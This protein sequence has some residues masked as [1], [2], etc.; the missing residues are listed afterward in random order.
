M[1]LYLLLYVYYIVVQS[2]EFR[3]RWC[4]GVNNVIEL[5]LVSNF[6]ELFNIRKTFHI[7][8]GNILHMQ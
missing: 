8:V 3:C 2:K 7:H 5:G 1:V 4:L 6:L